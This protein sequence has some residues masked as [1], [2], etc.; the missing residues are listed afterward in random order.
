MPT[1]GGKSLCYQIPSIV[2]KGTGIVVSPLIALMQDQVSALEALGV[3]AAYLNST[4]EP[5][6]QRE[7]EQRLLDGDLDLF[8]I[9]PERLLSERMLSLLGRPRLPSLRSM[10]LTVCRSGA[11]IFAPS[12]SNSRRW[13]TVSRCAAHRVDRNSGCAHAGGNLF[14][15]QAGKC[16]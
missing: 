2:R 12:I 7:V 9:A 1:G 10:R 5:W 15:T 6:A 14:R 13:L 8:Y 3:N 11:M 4:L 16:R